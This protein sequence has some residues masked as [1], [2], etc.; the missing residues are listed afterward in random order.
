MNQKQAFEEVM[1]FFEV[2]DDDQ[3]KVCDLVNMMSEFLGDS[4]EPI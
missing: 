4:E 1:R 2:N 3:L